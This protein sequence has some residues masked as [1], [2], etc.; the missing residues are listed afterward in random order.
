MGIA[1]TD[2]AMMAQALA[3]AR[4]AQACGEVPVGAVVARD[5][6]VIG[7]GRNR[8]IAQHDPSAHAEIMALRDAGARSGNHRLIGASMYVTLEPC[9]MCAGALLHARIERLIFAAHD[10]RFGAAGGALNLLDAPFAN[11]RCKI[12]AGVEESRARELLEDF[13]AARRAE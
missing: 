3:L 11:H 5:G 6:A 10:S 9:I 4:R 12:T 2:R 1:E 13:F 8:S 7:R